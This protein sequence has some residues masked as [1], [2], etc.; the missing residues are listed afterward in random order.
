MT[1]ETGGQTNTDSAGD[2]T[3]NVA[4]ETLLTGGDTIDSTA[5]GEQVGD[6]SGADDAQ[7]G[8]S[9]GDEGNGESQ[10]PESYQFNMPEGVNMDQAMAD[11][12]G[13]VFKELGLN[14]EQADKLTGLMA[15][16]IGRDAQ[17]QQD[18]FSKQL[19][20]WAT[21][22]KNDSDVGGISF[23][24]NAGIARQAIEQFGSPE[25]KELLDTSGMGNNPALFKFAL[26]VGKLLS[27]DQPGSGDRAGGDKS[28]ED[29]FY[30]N[31]AV[32][33]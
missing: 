14:Q 31:E 4:S 7:K 28:I 27:E 25:L 15:A 26:N 3:T 8:E 32:N 29:R 19:E 1:D 16:K 33:G 20:D 5:S 12:A 21:E 11:E 17:A 10:I 13:P 30:P 2:Q 18:A 24:K 6:E 23:G 22:L 9:N